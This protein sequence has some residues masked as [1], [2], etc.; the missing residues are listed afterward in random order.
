MTAWLRLLRPEQW[1]KN[2]FVLAALVFSMQF[3]D[4]ESFLRAWAA[5][6]VFCAAASSGYIL[7]DILDADRDRLHPEKASRPIAAGEVPASSAAVVGVVLALVALAGAAALN[8]GVLVAV[9]AY[10]TLQTAYSLA[11]KRIVGVDAIVISCGFV[12]RTAAGVAAVGAEMSVWLF[13]AT[14]TLALF[15]ALAKRRHELVLLGDRAL[16]HRDVLQ[17]YAD[18]PLDAMLVAVA[19]AVAGVYAQYTLRPEVGARLGTDSIYLTVPFVVLGLFRY[20]YLVYRRDLA[21]NPTTALL[22]D[23]PLQVS[24]ALWA[25][26]VL[27][28]LY[29]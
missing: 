2:V 11:L 22:I 6:S 27:F 29:A 20:L 8:N 21:G 3:T 10:L 26:T 19:T 17:H 13:L 12:L 15:L 25:A 4:G 1:V 28:L 23:R 14:F 5:F 7:N 9:A 18:L 24:V 16:D